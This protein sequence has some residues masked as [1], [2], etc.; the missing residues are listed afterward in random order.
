MM[1][2]SQRHH[3]ITLATSSSSL[4]RRVPLYDENNNQNYYFKNDLC[5]CDLKQ[6][7][8]IGNCFFISALHSIILYCVHTSPEHG[9]VYFYEK[10]GIW[11]TLN[12]IDEP[13][14]G[15]DIKLHNGFAFHT[16][17]VDSTLPCSNNGN[18]LYVYNSHG[19][20]W[21][22]FLEKAILKFLNK[23]Y[24]D[25]NEGG[26]P[27]QIFTL[28]FPFG[29][30]TI[31]RDNLHKAFDDEQNNYFLTGA[32]IFKNRREYAMP[33]GIITQHA[34][35]IF[36]HNNNLLIVN[37]WKHT[38]YRR[39][40]Q[41]LQQ[42]NSSFCQQQQK[43]EDEDG[44]WTITLDELNLN[45]N[46]LFKYT[47]V[48]PKTPDVIQCDKK[49]KLMRINSGRRILILILLER[50]LV[51]SSSTI[52][53][54]KCEIECLNDEKTKIFFNID[55]KFTKTHVLSMI[56]STRVIVAVSCLNY[57]K[58]LIKWL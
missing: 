51:V 2:N 20:F 37:P 26:L 1:G 34:Y 54:N 22:M 57:S 10:I 17:H 45:F 38:E 43:V 50:A 32:Y 27:A 12:D 25:W 15:F 13:D 23:T 58:F 47:F 41:D 48:M 14:Y 6:P 35:C 21:P 44:L 16:V 8:T 11:Q 40:L 29:K 18:W 56:F 42:N 5:L 28:L 19:E 36:K 55:D 33:S 30:Q 46:I 3:P 52:C 53:E 4:Y 7:N 49:S 9:L 39:Q 24:Q 31:Y